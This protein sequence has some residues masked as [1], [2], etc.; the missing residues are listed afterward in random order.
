MK[1][2]RNLYND[3]SKNIVKVFKKFCIHLCLTSFI[4]YTQDAC[5]ISPKE[6]FYI[7]CWM[8]L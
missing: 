6:I 1:K 2:L 8:R 4:I 7:V 3:K 5:I